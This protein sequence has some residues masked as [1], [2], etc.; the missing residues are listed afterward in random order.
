M[1]NT[2]FVPVFGDIEL[3]ENPNSPYDRNI[4]GLIAKTGEYVFIMR[5]EDGNHYAL[6]HYDCQKH[7][8]LCRLSD[9]YE[10]NGRFYQY[11]YTEGIVSWICKA[12]PEEISEENTWVKKHGKGL[13]HINADGF[14]VIETVGLSGD[15]W[16]NQ[17]V[18]D[19]YLIEWTNECDVAMNEFIADLSD[20][21]SN[22]K[23]D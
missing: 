20:E 21:L 3:K 5:S 7:K 12:S 9:V 14:Y 8:K 4:A 18:R 13:Y 1:S 16:D 23:E 22:E 6:L 10:L 17:E 11:N 19:D 15:N 2:V